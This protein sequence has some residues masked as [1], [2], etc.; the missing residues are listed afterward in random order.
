[1]GAFMII[2]Q[3][4]IA[5]L[6]LF[7]S[8]GHASLFA[9]DGFRLDDETSDPEALAIFGNLSAEAA[10]D[11][12]GR[13][14]QTELRFQG[15]R[16][17]F[18]RQGTRFPDRLTDITYLTAAR[19]SSLAED[20][21]GAFAVADLAFDSECKFF[22]AAVWQ[23]TRGNAKG[24]VIWCVTEYQP[25]LAFEGVYWANE[26]GLDWS[27]PIFTARWDGTWK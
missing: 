7:L 16:G 25:G 15:S 13:L 1:M 9:Q 10:F 19:A 22:I 23:V 17:T 11:V 27:D 20:K 5:I 12:D 8:S 3:L 2:K 18:R 14:I 24:R 4:L 21:A 6:W 26:K